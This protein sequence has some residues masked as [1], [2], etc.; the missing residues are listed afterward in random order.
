MPGSYGWDAHR[1][2]DQEPEPDVKLYELHRSKD[3][4]ETDN[5][6]MIYE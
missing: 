3:K 4:P 2:T 1:N 5:C 6:W